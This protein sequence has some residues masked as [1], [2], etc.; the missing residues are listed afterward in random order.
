M[1]RVQD[2]GEVTRLD[3]ARTLAGRGRYWTSAYLVDDLLVDSGCAHASHEVLEWLAPGRIATILNTHTHED[4]I[5]ANG[6]L[7]RRDPGISIRVHPDGLPVLSD[8]RNRQ[9][10]HPYQRVMWGW[11]TASHGSP[12]N[13]GDIVETS[14]FRFQAI[15]TPGHADDH[16][17]YWE[18]DRGWLFSGDLFVGGRERALRADYDIWGIIKSLKKIA[19][20]DAAIL[21]PGSAKVRENPGPEIDRKIDYLED[22]GGRI[23]EQHRQG[24]SVRQIVKALLGPPLLLEAITLGHFSREQLVRSCLRRGNTTAT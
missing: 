7:Q 20:L 5:G 9:P 1:L 22:V 17:S 16:L 18:P 21:F 19:R 23:L 15:Y 10:L 13:D 3:L 14:S 4:H 12:V 2:H 8:P 6:S 11:P 24:K